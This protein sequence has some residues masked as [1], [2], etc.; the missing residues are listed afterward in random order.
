MK[1][2][3]FFREN[4]PQLWGY[5]SYPFECEYEYNGRYELSNYDDITNNLSRHQVVNIINTLQEEGVLQLDDNVQYVT[6]RGYHSDGA[7]CIEVW[8]RNQDGATFEEFIEL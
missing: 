7:E 6:I 3:K 8:V 4:K 2:F 1:D 5:I